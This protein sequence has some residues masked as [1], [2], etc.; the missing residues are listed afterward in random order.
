MTKNLEDLIPDIY[1]IFQGEHK[2]SEENLNSFLQNLGES[3]KKS[4]EEAGTK[5]T[6]NLRMSVIGL[7]DRKLYYMV[8]SDIKQTLAP[9]QYIKFLYG[10]FVEQLVLFLTKEAGHSVS[11]E[12]K[13]VNI[14]GVEGSMDCKIDGVVTD[15]K[16]ASKFAIRKF[17]NDTLFKEDSFGYI[18]Q[19][20]GYAQAEGQNE[21]AFLVVNKEDGELVLLK[22][23]DLDMINAEERISHLKEI[24]E[25]K[26]LPEKC[27]EDE[28][29]GTSG[30][31]SLNS[32]CSYCQ[33]KFDCWADANGGEGL[34]VFD[35]SN[36]HKYFTRV[37]KRPRVEEVG[38]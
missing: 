30:N 12:Q 28:P 34:K 22:V 9:H 38:A 14:G 20:S 36:G 19:I 8:N 11:D 5:D 4:I 10:H 23:P 37:V 26:V 25:K 31:R 1:K 7:P 16:S 6:K 24:L 18:G 3:L 13:K 2:V 15:V 35:Y 32:D 29:E 21:A 17:K 27:H 33:F